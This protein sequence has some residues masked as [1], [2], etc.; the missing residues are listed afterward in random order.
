[1]AVAM[2]ERL[3]EQRY[4][5]CLGGAWERVSRVTHC[6]DCIPTGCRCSPTCATAWS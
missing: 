5:E 3:G 2:E 6:V 4:R 1:M